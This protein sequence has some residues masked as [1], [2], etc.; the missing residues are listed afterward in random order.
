MKERI[1]QEADMQIL[2]FG[3]RR[4]T[5]N[6]IASNLGISKKTIYKY[7][8]SKRQ[9]ISEVVD[10]ALKRKQDYVMQIMQ[11]EGDWLEKLE[12]IIS[13]EREEPPDWMVTELRRFFPEEWVK[14]QDKM[15]FHREQ[16]RKLLMH[17]IEKGD[18]KPD[19]HPAVIDLVMHKSI[20]GLLETDF[21]TENNLT[22]KKA[23]EDIKSI[24]LRGI[25]AKNYQPGN[26]G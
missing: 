1:I 2:K 14:I 5:V 4:F 21:L 10:N 11:K 15:Q 20:E 23:R 26:E 16:V 19:I 9:L 13:M 22:F 6:D 18:I 8:D 17:G 24:I 25:L 3:F 12:A 7:F